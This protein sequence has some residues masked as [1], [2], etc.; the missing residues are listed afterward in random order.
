[1]EDRLEAVEDICNSLVKGKKAEA[2]RIARSRYPFEPFERH[3]QQGT[4][5][6]AMKIFVRDG[7]LFR[8]R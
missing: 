4:I 6:Q 1:M 7:F 2:K 8:K 3:V 5:L